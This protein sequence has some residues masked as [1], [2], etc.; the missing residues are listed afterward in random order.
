M[1]YLGWIRESDLKTIHVTHEIMGKPQKQSVYN[2]SRM[3]PR[4]QSYDSQLDP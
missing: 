2:G 3:N 4:T 1:I